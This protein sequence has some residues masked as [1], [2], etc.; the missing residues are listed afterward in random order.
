M[1]EI[2]C[3]TTRCHNSEDPNLHCLVNIKYT[4]EYCVTQR[5]R[6][7]LCITPSIIISLLLASRAKIPNLGATIAGY[8]YLVELETQWEGGGALIHLWQKY[9]NIYDFVRF[10]Y[11][12]FIKNW[13]CCNVE[14]KT[15]LMGTLPLLCSWKFHDSRTSWR[16]SIWKI[17]FHT[18]STSVFGFNLKPN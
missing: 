14:V 16:K 8:S 2:T 18:A 4:Y 5:S 17:V 10:R 12:L 1:L 3:H 9:T 6:T 13:K 7:I 11:K 15:H